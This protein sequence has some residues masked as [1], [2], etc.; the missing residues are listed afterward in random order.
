MLS[1]FYSEGRHYQVLTEMTYHKRDD[2]DI[3]RVDGFIKSSNGNVHRKRKARVR[4]ILLEWK[5]GPLDWIT[6]KE[7]KYSS[8]VKIPENIVVNAISDEAAF[9]WC[10]KETLHHRYRIISKVKSKYYRTSHKFG[11]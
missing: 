11:I 7:I 9:I 6:Q 3:T 8:P 4:K 2:I 5:D 10:I 1:K